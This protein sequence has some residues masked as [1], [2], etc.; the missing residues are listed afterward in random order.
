M[1]RG[2]RQKFLLLRTKDFWAKVIF[3]HLYVIMFTGGSTWAGTP[4]WPVTPLSVILFTG[5][6][7]WTGPPLQVQSPRQLPQ[8]ALNPLPDRSTP[9]DVHMHPGKVQPPTQVPTGKLTPSPI[10]DPP[11][12]PRQIR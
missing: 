1:N 6:G 5:C 11:P 9:S 7:T 12:P 4:P 10:P 3:L 8:V 2:E